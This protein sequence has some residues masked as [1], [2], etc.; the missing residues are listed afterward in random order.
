MCG[1]C[2]CV[3]CAF[4]LICVVAHLLSLKSRNLNVL[5]DQWQNQVT[6]GRCCAGDVTVA[7]PLQRPLSRSPLQRHR[8][9]HYSRPRCRFPRR[10]RTQREAFD[11]PPRDVRGRCLCQRR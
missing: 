11:L 8:S 4:Y 7:L 9:P 5:G 6:S 2:I 1:C 3:S 10:F